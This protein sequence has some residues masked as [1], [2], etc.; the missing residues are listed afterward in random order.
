MNSIIGGKEFSCLKCGWK[1]PVNN[2]THDC[3]SCLKQQIRKQEQT[4][5]SLN[6]KN[7]ALM[8]R[9]FRLRKHQNKLLDDNGLSEVVLER[10]KNREMLDE[11]GMYKYKYVPKEQD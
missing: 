5:K 11:N 3:I 7:T 9:N 1:S 10:V 2:Y 6:R 4:I 8:D